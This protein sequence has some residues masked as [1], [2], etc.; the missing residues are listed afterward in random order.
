MH[1]L[2]IILSVDI[3]QAAAAAPIWMELPSSRATLE[4]CRWPGGSREAYHRRGPIQAAGPMGN[5]FVP[6]LEGVPCKELLHHLQATQHQQCVPR[7]R[8]PESTG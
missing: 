2:P 1:A 7:L 3:E 8:W 4:H 6:S 5:D